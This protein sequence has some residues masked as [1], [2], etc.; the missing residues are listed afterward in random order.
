MRSEP[1]QAEGLLWARLKGSQLGVAFRRQVVLGEAQGKLYVA[2]FYAPAAR[3]VV[4]VDGASHSNREGADA[5]RDRALERLGYRVLR[6]SNACVE[7]DIE[8]AVRQVRE[9]LQV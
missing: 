3:L 9:A 6:V 7:R 5:R 4:E 1:T 8:E 2:D